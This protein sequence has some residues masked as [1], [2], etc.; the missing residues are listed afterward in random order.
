MF[1]SQV[2]SSCTIYCTTSTNLTSGGHAALGCMLPGLLFSDLVGNHFYELRRQVSYL[3]LH[4]FISW[5]KGSAL[6]LLWHL[7]GSDSLS[8]STDASTALA[9]E[10]LQMA[11]GRSQI[12]L[13][14]FPCAHP[15]TSR[16]VKFKCDA[17][18][19]FP[20]NVSWRIALTRAAALTARRAT[21]K[22][23]GGER[24]SHIG[25]EHFISVSCVPGGKALPK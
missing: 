19:C 25:T 14:F 10:L 2:I 16:L 15:G 1:R 13:H 17:E 6:S 21:L 18:T 7:S 9:V 4:H 20:S 22:Q 3:W 8:L 12:R 5:I 23:R 11:A 24:K